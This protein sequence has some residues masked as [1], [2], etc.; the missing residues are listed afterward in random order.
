MLKS[1]LVKI[2]QKEVEELGDHTLLEYKIVDAGGGRSGNLYSPTRM[3]HEG[4]KAKMS[5]REYRDFLLDERI[6]VNGLGPED[7]K[8]DGALGEGAD[9]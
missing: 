4:R 2:L 9:R 3:I 5:F 8:T 7:L 1:E 6:R